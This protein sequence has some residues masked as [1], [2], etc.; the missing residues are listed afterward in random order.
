[1]RQG[2]AAPLEDAAPEAPWRL[3]ARCASVIPTRFPILVALALLAL[4][5]S[6]AQPAGATIRVCFL[7]VDVNCFWW[8]GERY[9]HCDVYAAV[10]RPGCVEVSLS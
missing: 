1:M 9:V 5:V 3:A 10:P 2:G 6:P 7:P 4:A 8:N